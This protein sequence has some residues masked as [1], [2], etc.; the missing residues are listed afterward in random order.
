MVFKNQKSDVITRIIKAYE[1]KRQKEAFEQ[2]Q[3]L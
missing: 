1:S 2:N 3:K